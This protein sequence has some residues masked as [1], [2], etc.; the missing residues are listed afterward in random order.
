MK[1]TKE[2]IKTLKLKENHEKSK[3]VSSTLGQ[4]IAT[5][6]AGQNFE[7]EMQKNYREGEQL[8]M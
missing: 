4:I 5:K 6:Q 7:M 1:H 8:K 2:K 3:L